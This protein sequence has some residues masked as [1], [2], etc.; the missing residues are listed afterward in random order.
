VL[1]YQPN[2]L[3][4]TRYGFAVGR[5]VGKAVE[6]N[7][8]RRLLREAA[9]L[10]PVRPGADIVLIARPA[11]AGAGYTEVRAAVTELLRR[12]RL[13]AEPEQP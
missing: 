8:V 11:A 3:D 12:A 6:R 7:R 9:R 2:G 5:R 10:T 1:R 13:L 4:R